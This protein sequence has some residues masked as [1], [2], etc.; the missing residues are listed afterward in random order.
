M[1]DKRKRLIGLF[2]IAPIA[3]FWSGCESTESFAEEP[4]PMQPAEPIQVSGTQLDP[5]NMGKV[6]T[7]EAIHAYYIG[8]YVDPQD[9][10]IRH[11]G[12]RI[13]RV[14]RPAQ[15]NLTPSAPTAV[16]LGPVVAVADPAKQT[17]LLTGELENKITQANNLIAALI[18]QNDQLQGELQRKD[19]A[20]E[21]LS[22]RISNLED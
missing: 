13:S 9:S 11:D 12:H 2:A 7:P 15:W 3:L 21:N 6:R 18:E 5:Y 10:G 16:P 14:E 20:I 1:K 8:P 4:P 19:K 17:A 22:Q